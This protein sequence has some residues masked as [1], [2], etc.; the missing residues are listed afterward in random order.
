MPRQKT[1][2]SGIPKGKRGRHE[3]SIYKLPNGYWRGQV[4]IG[5]KED[6]SRKFI[7]KNSKSRKEIADWLL[8]KQ[9]DVN[10]NTFIEPNSI[11]VE[12]YLWN[13]MNLYKKNTVSPNTYTRYIVMMRIHVAPAMKK[14][15]LQDLRPI[16]IQKLYNDLFE[17]GMSYSARKHIHTLF[18]QALQCAVNEGLI[19]K[20]Y[21]LNTTR[22]K[23]Q[24][25]QE[26]VEVF[27]PQEQ[28]LIINSTDIS[29]I[30]VLVRLALGTGCRMGEL[31]AL[32]WSDI[33]FDQS[34]I[35]IRHGLTRANQFSEDGRSIEGYKKE[36]GGLKTK[37]SKRDIPVAENTL[38]ML[39]K[40]KLCQKSFI[41]NED[42]IPEYVF[43][44]PEGNL[45][46]ESNVRKRYKTF[47]KSI[48]VKYRKFHCLRHSYAT[49][50]ME[51][52]GSSKGCSTASG[53]L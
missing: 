27:T 3:G 9:K 28:M 25:P 2:N 17:E 36:V 42:L 1:E 48:G 4:Q 41:K 45:W 47:L 31:L 12:D 22:P 46:N 6:G 34:I 11:L 29:P 13:W 16:H 40:Y 44:T 5:F 18:N 7:T 49:R 37:H 43:L 20:N 33:D 23:D 26:E 35:H 24:K 15:K 21:A 39:R 32:T 8:E 52:R 30:P 10:A 38:Q 53:T 19:E 51:Q 50:L 14:I